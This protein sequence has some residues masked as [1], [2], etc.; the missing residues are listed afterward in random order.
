MEASPRMLTATHPGHGRSRSAGQGRCAPR[1]RSLLRSQAR[2]ALPPA[3]SPREGPIRH[4]I[5]VDHRNA[6]LRECLADAKAFGTPQRLIAATVWAAMLASKRE[7][8]QLVAP[9]RQA[10]RREP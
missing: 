1:G 4:G 8:T 7:N 9:T 6:V 2:Y 10:L 3:P 5:P